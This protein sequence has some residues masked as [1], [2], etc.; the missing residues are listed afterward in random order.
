MGLK[1]AMCPDKQRKIGSG[2]SWRIPVQPARS[3]SWEQPALENQLP[4]RISPSKLPNGATLYCGFRKI[5]KVRATRQSRFSESLSVLTPHSLC[6]GLFKACPRTIHY[7]S[8][9]TQLTSGRPA[10]RILRSS[11]PGHSPSLPPPGYVSWFR[12]ALT[13]G[14]IWAAPLQRT[15]RFF[16]GKEHRRQL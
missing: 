11:L 9:L 2:S 10:S 15:A 12:A 8:S 7:W 14:T 3:P 4:W 1:V 6:K 13:L 16:R 5:S